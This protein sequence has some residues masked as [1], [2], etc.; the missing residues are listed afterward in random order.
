MR[1][2][3]LSTS[4]LSRIVGGVFLG[5]PIITGPLAQA[6]DLSSAYKAPPLA[7][8]APAVDGFNEKFDAFGGSIDKLSIYGTEGSFSLPL[9]SQFGAQFDGRVGGL[10]GSAFGSGAGHFFWRNPT[11]GLVGVYGDTTEWNRFGG[12][13]VS[14]VA[15]EG[16]YYWGAVTF[17]GIA[18]VEFGNAVSSTTST[19]GLIN[20]TPSSLTQGFDVRTRFFD[21]F[22]AKYYFTDNVSGYVGQDYLG[23]KNALAL[24]GE[25]AYPL[26]HGI[27]TSAFVEARLGEGE[28]RGVWGGLKFY[29]GQKDKALEARQRQDDPETWSS[30][31]L[32]GILNNST[33]NGIP[34][35]C[36]SGEIPVGGRCEFISSDIR[37]KRDIVLLDT[38]DDGLGIYRYRY[39]WSETLYVGVMAQEVETI[40][41]DAV[42]R[43]KD[44]YLRVNYS[45]LGLRLMSWDEWCDKAAAGMADLAA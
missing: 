25:F 40:V 11:Q 21:Q 23:G 22:K 17:E 32:F 3:L 16:A 26:G 18:G 35:S 38:T 15:G 2:K 39:L 4:M 6:A 10:D 5:G 45:R 31:A 27:M 28:F 41:P 12:V 13:N 14:R 36:H 34:S 7:A 20:G 9:A 42:S 44:G 37:L 19:S 8:P 43:G 29:F 33:R 30:D 1:N 24:G